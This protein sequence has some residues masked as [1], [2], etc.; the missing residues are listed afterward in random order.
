MNGTS[1]SIEIFKP[2]GE[3]FE[4]MKKMLFQPFDISKWCVVGFAAFLAGNFGGGGGGFSWPN[5]KHGSTAPIPWHGSPD[6]HRYW[7]W[8]TG[9]FVTIFLSIFALVILLMWIRARGTFIFTDCI[10]HNRGAIKQ[11]WREYRAEGNSYFLFSLVFGFGVL[12]IFAALICFS[13]LLIW[14]V[15]L[16]D[17]QKTILFVI[18]GVLA[19][20]AWMFF[21]IVFG[22]ISYFMPPIMYVRRCRALDAFREVLRLVMANLTPFVLFGLFSIVL[23]LGLMVAGMIAACATCC[24]AALPYVG[25]VIMLP[26][27]VWI[28]AFGLLFLRQFGPEFDVWQGNPPLPAA[29][30]P[31]P[32]P[33]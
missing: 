15:N 10:V 20:L 17:T 28:R 6:F 12:A 18:L 33:A 9:L 32:L 7:P 31:P 21:A 26:A 2:F 16:P 29:P 14:M 11:P 5:G 8:M 13:V 25:S 30:S 27:I 3:A 24:L 4:L 19:F 22:L 1:S 23:F